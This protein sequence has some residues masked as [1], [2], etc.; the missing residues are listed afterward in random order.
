MHQSPPLD[1]STLD[2][3]AMDVPSDA[4]S[5]ALL[6]RTAWRFQQLTQLELTK[7]SF[8]SALVI[9]LTIG[10]F[11]RCFYNFYLHPLRKIPGP[12]L[13]AVTS[14]P[15]F[16]YDVIKDGSYLFE[17]RKMHDH[18]GEFGLLSIPDAWQVSYLGSHDFW[19]RVEGYQG[20]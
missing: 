7:S 20:F 5:M 15:D 10:I 2:P 9:I 4:S 11:S 17:I 6:G 3:T 13:A 16:Y 14:W 1:L 19:S 18:Y 12:K 8:A